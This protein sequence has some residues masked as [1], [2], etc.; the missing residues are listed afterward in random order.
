MLELLKSTQWAEDDLRQAGLW[1]R[2]QAAARLG[3]AFWALNPVAVYPVAYLIQRSILMAT[4]WVVLMFLSFLR[5]LATGLCYALAMLSKEYAVSSILLLVPLYVFY[6]RPR[7]RRIGSVLGI[8]VLLFG[9]VGVLLYGQLSAAAA[10][11][12]EL[13]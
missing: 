13:Q 10:D 9:V 3:G 5:G 4:L 11:A 6:K 12:C 2:Q 1:S 8:A 7:A